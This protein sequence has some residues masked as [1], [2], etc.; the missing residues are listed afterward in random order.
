M[1]TV[2]VPSFFNGEFGSGA[3]ILVFTSTLLVVVFFV[4]CATSNFSAYNG[5]FS[6]LFNLSCRITIV[7]STVIVILCAA[8]NNF[9]TTSAASFVRTVVVAV[10]LVTILYFNVGATNN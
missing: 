9:L 7:I 5:L 8:L 1:N 4:P 6:S 3:R 10:T 2:A